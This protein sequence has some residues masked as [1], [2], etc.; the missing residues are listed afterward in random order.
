M[1]TDF[2]PQSRGVKQ[3]CSLTPTLFDI[4]IDQ[5]AK[6]LEESEIPGLTLSD[7]EV[8]CLLL[9]DDLILLTPSKEALQKQQD[10]LLKFCQT[11]AL[12]VNLEKTKVMVF[13]KC[14]KNPHR[15]HLDSTDIENTHSY[16][17]LGLN[18]TS[19]GNFNLAIKDLR[20][21]SRRALWNIKKSSNTDIPVKIWIKI[22][23]SIIE[24]IG[25]YGSEM[26][27]PYMN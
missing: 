5:L 20:D 22:F 21:K 23:Q 19:T 2:F 3:G 11:W 8:K 18:I 10:Q 1:E 25:L 6:S 27:D 12:T 7:I 24:P 4:Y 9:A 15:F 16:T 13:Q 26:W 17:Y 14:Q